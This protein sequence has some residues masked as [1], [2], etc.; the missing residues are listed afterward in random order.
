MH[1]SAEKILIMAAI[2]PIKMFLD[3]HQKTIFDLLTATD[4]NITGEIK[5]SRKDM[6]S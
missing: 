6:I 5:K 2:Q 3:D 1:A 4:K